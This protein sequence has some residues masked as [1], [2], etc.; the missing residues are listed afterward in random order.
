MAGV[1]MSDPHDDG[2]ALD[3]EWYTGPNLLPLS[4]PQTTAKPKFSMT[5][6]Y[7][8]D[9]ADLTAA[10]NENM[11]QFA[12][13]EERARK[14]NRLLFNMRAYNDHIGDPQTLT[15]GNT[16]DWGEICA[17]RDRVERFDHKHPMLEQILAWLRKTLTP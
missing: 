15:L 17:D 5:S 2:P 12:A 13:F 3:P 8:Q 7:A 16:A 4:S 10:Q 6:F 9:A 1:P 14:I 11:S